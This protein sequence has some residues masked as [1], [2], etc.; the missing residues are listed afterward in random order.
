MDV[1]YR[2]EMV[3]AAEFAELLERSGLA[4]RRPVG[5]RARLQR[6]IDHADLIVTARIGA[7][8]IG[9]GGMGT[10][11]AGDNGR[12]VGI[13]RSLTDWS[14]AAYL[15]DLAV[16]AAY[17][18]K[19]IGKRLIAETRRLAGEEAMLLLVAAPDA[20]GYYDGIGMARSDRAFLY[21]R[22]R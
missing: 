17:Q 11:G 5:D 21:P 19:G 10:A 14:Y 20:A 13:A 9:A 4:A 6:M 22:A 1:A 16:D 3:S 12:L 2:Q 7:G 18:K 8:R 15:S